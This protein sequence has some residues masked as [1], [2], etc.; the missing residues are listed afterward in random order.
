VPRPN[1]L[2]LGPCL[3]FADWALEIGSGGGETSPIFLAV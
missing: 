3:S 2:R 1:G